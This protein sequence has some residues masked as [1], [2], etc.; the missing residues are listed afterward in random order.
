MRHPSVFAADCHLIDAPTR[1]LELG[2]HLAQPLTSGFS[3]TN[4]ERAQ[5]R[6]VLGRAVTVAELRRGVGTA[7]AQAQRD[8]MAGGPPWTP[9][10]RS[11][12]RPR[13]GQR[14]A[15]PG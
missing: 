3:C 8:A 10:A 4:A 6:T 1:E 5:V 12:G 15:G 9:C 13:A 11:I 2:T 7:V 14:T